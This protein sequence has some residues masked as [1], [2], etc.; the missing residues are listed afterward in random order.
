MAGFLGAE[1]RFGHR[2]SLRSAGT[3][4]IGSLIATLYTSRMVDAAFTAA[5]EV[6]TRANDSIGAA[7]AAAATLPA[8]QAAHLVTTSSQAYTD[9]LGIGLAVAAAVALTAA[10]AVKRQL[11]ARHL[12]G[13][14]TVAAAA[15]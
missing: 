12:A 9:A 11:P 3:A 15:E 8:D 14:P 6:R 4:V 10:I 2:R 1:A 5:P 7:Q 13:A